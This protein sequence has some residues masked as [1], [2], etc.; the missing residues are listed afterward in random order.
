MSS[1]Q[2]EAGNSA[3]GKFRINLL[4]G[5]AED[6]DSGDDMSFLE[7]E[8]EQEQSEDGA[9]E[10]VDQAEVPMQMDIIVEEEHIEDGV[11]VDQGLQQQ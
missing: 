1:K 5:A 11:G 2:S 4:G 9:Y 3:G 8:G 10:H 7:E 6:E